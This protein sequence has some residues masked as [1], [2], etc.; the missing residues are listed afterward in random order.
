MIMSVPKYPLYDY[1]HHLVTIP[2]NGVFHTIPIEDLKPENP[3]DGYLNIG[4]MYIDIGPVY[5]AKINGVVQRININNE[6]IVGPPTGKQM[7]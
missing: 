2:F 1:K 4:S 6:Y 3:E 5:R 7:Q